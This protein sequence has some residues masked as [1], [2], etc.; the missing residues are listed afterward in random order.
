MTTQPC[1][2]LVTIRSFIFFLILQNYEITYD[3]YTRWLSIIILNICLGRWQNKCLILAV[4]PTVSRY[5]CVSLI[6]DI[7][8]WNFNKHKTKTTRNK[9]AFKSFCLP[10]FTDRFLSCGPTHFM[11]KLWAS[12]NRSM[13]TKVFAYYIYNIIPIIHTCIQTH[14]H[15]EKSLL[16]G[17]QKICAA[18]ANICQLSCVLLFLSFLF[19]FTF[20]IFIYSFAFQSQGPG[21]G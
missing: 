10:S 19:S 16:Q 9:N 18:C 12:N 1:C 14:T 7:C 21:P 4:W 3:L 11:R 13:L 17:G 6:L 5:Q 2:S 15:T 20:C 8:T